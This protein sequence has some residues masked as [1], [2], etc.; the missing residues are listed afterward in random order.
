MTKKAPP[1][2]KVMKCTPAEARDLVPTLAGLGLAN[3]DLRDEPRGRAGGDG[4][5]AADVATDRA[6]CGLSRE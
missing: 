5:D 4:L 2:S 3:V 6:G 1:K